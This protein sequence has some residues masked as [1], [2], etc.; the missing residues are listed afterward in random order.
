MVEWLKS[1]MNIKTTEGKATSGEFVQW[2][3]LFK[4]KKKRRKVLL[5]LQRTWSFWSEWAF[6]IDWAFCMM[7]SVISLVSDLGEIHLF[8][9]PKISLNLSWPAS[10]FPVTDFNWR[11][12]GLSLFFLSQML[13]GMLQ[14][15]KWFHK[16][17]FAFEQK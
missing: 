9:P 17:P 4:K 16:E 13:L 5:S 14:K 6:N 7:S 2:F 10:G 11:Q 1:Q 8:R 3:T 15:M 12:N